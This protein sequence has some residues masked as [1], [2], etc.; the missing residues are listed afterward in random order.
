MTDPMLGTKFSRK[1]SSPH[2]IGKSTPNNERKRVTTMPVI[3]LIVVLI[4]M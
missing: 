1:A 4:A 2:R 3:T